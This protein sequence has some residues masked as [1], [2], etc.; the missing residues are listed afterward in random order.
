MENKDY[1]CLDCGSTNLK[2]IYRN[3]DVMVE[4]SNMEIVNYEE[5]SFVECKDCGNT[6]EMMYR[7][8][9]L[10]LKNIP[11]IKAIKGIKE[12]LRKL[13]KVWDE[14]Y[15]K[16][17]CKSMRDSKDKILYNLSKLFIE[18][19]NSCFKHYENGEYFE[20]KETKKYL[21]DILI[22]ALDK[23]EKGRD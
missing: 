17:Y 23:Y 4:E 22:P 7:K 12:D 19:Y 11:T 18:K 21:E 9:Y 3:A 2:I 13:R 8:R 20:M 16:Y 15:S 10:K 5:T 14:K 1:C 6:D